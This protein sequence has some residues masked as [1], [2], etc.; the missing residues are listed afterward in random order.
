MD[1]YWE[2][3]AQFEK[4]GDKENAVKM[5]TYMRNLFLFYGLPT[6]KRKTIYKDFLKSEKKSKIVDWD[7]LDKCYDDEYREF[8]YL[9]MDY[10]V[11]MQKFLTYDDVPHIKRYIKTKQ[12][13]DTIDRQNYRKYCFC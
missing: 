1:M 6:P 13:W 5:A 4:N 7:F 2:I 3:K 8:Q 10:L 12:W 9:V 11:V